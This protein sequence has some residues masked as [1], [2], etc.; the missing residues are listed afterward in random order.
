MAWLIC[1][2]LVSHLSLSYSYLK[3]IIFIYFIFNNTIY[4]DFHL[5]TLRFYYSLKRIVVQV[6]VLLHIIIKVLLHIVNL[7]DSMEKLKSI[8]I[9]NKI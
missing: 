6:L 8:K 5:L 4:L 7:N 9:N 1:E 3:K 2:P